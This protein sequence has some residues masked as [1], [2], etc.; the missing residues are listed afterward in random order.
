MANVKKHFQETGVPAADLLNEYLQNCDKTQT[1]IT[2]ELGALTGA[3]SFGSLM[4]QWKTGRSPIPL[5]MVLPLCRIIDAE[6][7]PMF[8][9]ILE[10]QMPDAL[11]A[12]EHLSGQ[13]F[14]PGER[15]M[16]D[17]VIETV[18][19]AKNAF[20]KESRSP[21]AEVVAT[22]DLSPERKAAIKAAIKKATVVKYSS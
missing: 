17:L 15:V 7:G 13:S 16:H 19:E 10:H 8:Q 2:K 9:A 21:K 5:R 20:K 11:V 12:L 14:S 1:E 4:T 3:R 6:P 18:N 22:F